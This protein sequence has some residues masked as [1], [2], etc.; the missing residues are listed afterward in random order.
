ME[1]ER[2]YELVRFGPADER[3]SIF[4]YLED[5]E[6]ELEWPSSRYALQYQQHRTEDRLITIMCVLQ[7]VN[8]TNVRSESVRDRVELTPHIPLKTTQIDDRRLFIVELIR[9]SNIVEY[10]GPLAL[11]RWGCFFGSPF[12]ILGPQGGNISPNGRRSGAK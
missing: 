10:N 8:E 7:I 6:R 4:P 11:G 2:L 5:I 12:P 3:R 9:M 1:S